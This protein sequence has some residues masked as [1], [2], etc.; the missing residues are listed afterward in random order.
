MRRSAS[1]TSSSR[2]TPSWTWPATPR[3]RST[4]RP[5]PLTTFVVGYAAA[6]RGGKPSDLEDCIDIATELIAETA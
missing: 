3:T 2:W 1:S 5:R 4:D 6:L